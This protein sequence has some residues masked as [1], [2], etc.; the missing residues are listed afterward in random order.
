MMRF[1]EEKVISFMHFFHLFPLHGSG[2][3]PMLSSM[4]HVALGKFKG[5][6]VVSSGFKGHT[7]L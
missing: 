3:E 1:I 6:S 2:M 4:C 7:Y 5:P